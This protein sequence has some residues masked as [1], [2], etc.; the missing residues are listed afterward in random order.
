MQSSLA[1]QLARLSPL[2]LA[3]ARA[4]LNAAE[5]WLLRRSSL[6][7]DQ[8]RAR[9]RGRRTGARGAGAGVAFPERPTP[10]RTPSRRA[11]RTR[12]TRRS[13]L[14]APVV[15]YSGTFEAYQGLSELVAAIPRSSSADTERPRSCWSA[16]IAR[17][18]DR[19]RHG[20]ELVEPGCLADRGAPAARIEMAA[21]LALADVLVSPRAYGGNLPLKIFDYLAA[22]RPIVATDIPTHRTVLAEER[23]V[24]VEPARNRGAGRGHSR[25]CSTTRSGRAAWPPPPASYAQTHLGWNRFVDSVETLYAEVERHA[26]VVQPERREPRP[27]RFG[28]HPGTQRGS[29]DRRLI[30]TIQHQAPAGWTRRGRAGRRRIHRRHR[31]RRHARPG[32][33]CSSSATGQ[34]AAI[35][36]WPGT[37]GARAAGGD[38]L[39]FLDADCL[40]APGWL[41]PAPGG[42]RRRR[43]GGG[44]RARPAYRAPAD[45]AL[46]LLLRVVPRALPPPGRRGAQPSPGQ[47]E[48]PPRCVRPHPG[49]TEQQPIAY[50]HEELVWQA[51][52]RRTGGRIVFD[53]SAIVYHYN[54]PGFR[55]LLRRNYRWGYSAIESKAPTGAARMAWVYRYPALLVA[56]SLPLA[57]GERR[58]H[59]VVL[60]S[61]RRARA[62]P[63]AARRCSPRGW[64]T[65]RASSPGASAGCASAPP[66]RRHGRDGS[67]WWDGADPPSRSQCSIVA[68][69]SSTLPDA[70][71]R[72]DV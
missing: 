71:D 15:L 30:S 14:R 24:L 16:R 48:R 53:P 35:L 27:N 3:P 61:G 66:R 1:E 36:P 62:A 23:A 63:D 43:G 38:P 2:A 60:A 13:R 26:G 28:H 56:A 50:A 70:S 68:L 11:G 9:R 52:V 65:R 19:A 37:A 72:G 55:N 20:G 18:G 8:R 25:P 64:P 40:P 54:R 7:V 21:F 44:R 10:T 39:V 31:R 47:S 45:G 49:F 57:A 6:V 29:D 12:A 46:R 33:A 22:G 69:S 67:K 42:T 58:V 4:A 34:G 5:R 59:H 17:T 32:H 41:R 51:E